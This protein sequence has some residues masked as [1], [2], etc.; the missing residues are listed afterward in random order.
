MTLSSSDAAGVWKI[1]ALKLTDNVGNKASFGDL[2]SYG[3]P[4]SIEIIGG[5]ESVVPTLNSISVNQAT[6][7]VTDGPQQIIFTVDATDESGI[8]WSAGIN[9]TNVILQH[10]NGGVYH[11]AVGDNDD[12]GKLSVTLSSSDAAGEWKIYAFQLTDNVVNKSGFV[13]LE[14]YGLPASI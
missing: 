14:S 1:Y 7:D 2:E 4:A 13:Y 6:F 10:P 11:Y 9:R 5:A 3:L 12:S 8:N